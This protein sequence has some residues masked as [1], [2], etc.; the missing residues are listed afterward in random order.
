MNDAGTNWSSLAPKFAFAH[1]C[2]LH[3]G[4][5]AYEIV[6]GTKP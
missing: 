6:F 3:N 1:K 2:Q 4:N 5:T